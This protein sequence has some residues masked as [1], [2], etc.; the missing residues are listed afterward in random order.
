MFMFEDATV[1]P[2]VHFWNF[3]LV[4][5]TRLD[6]FFFPLKI[7]GKNLE[8][9]LVAQIDFFGVIFNPLDLTETS[10]AYVYRVQNTRQM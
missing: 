9:F 3:F 8:K 1:A 6:F 7:F 10:I 4:E 5:M 2:N